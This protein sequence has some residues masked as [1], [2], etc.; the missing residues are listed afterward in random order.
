L[1]FKNAAALKPDEEL[2]PARGKTVASLSFAE[3]HC[4]GERA[5]ANEKATRQQG[6]PSLQGR[7]VPTE[8]RPS[9]LSGQIVGSPYQRVKQFL[10]LKLLYFQ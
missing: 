4:N 9:K 1:K 7:I 10:G 5:A 8:A 3:R 2:H 6:R